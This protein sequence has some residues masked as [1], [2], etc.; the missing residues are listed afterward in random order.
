MFLKV[1]DL[2]PILFSVFV[3]HAICTSLKK[4]THN[5]IKEIFD[6]T[7]TANI[8]IILLFIDIIIYTSTFT[9]AHSVVGL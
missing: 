9:E 7:Y 1:L 4:I 3:V 5:Y 8:N 2:V 6:V